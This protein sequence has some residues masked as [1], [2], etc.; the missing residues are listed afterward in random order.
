M[1]AANESHSLDSHKGVV[2]R[3][4]EIL[5]CDSFDN[6][7]IVTLKLSVHKG[8]CQPFALTD[9]AIELIPIAVV[10]DTFCL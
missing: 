8:G 1:S 2:E 7:G 3:D 10:G 9:D 5:T 6:S 4:G